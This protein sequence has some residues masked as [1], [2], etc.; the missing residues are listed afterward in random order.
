[1]NTNSWAA[2]VHHISLNS[3]RQVSF[4]LKFG[5]DVGGLGASQLLRMLGGSDS[6]LAALD[7]A[8]Q[9]GDSDEGE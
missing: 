1:M 8:S 4:T 2:V 5:S 3:G 6:Q 7:A 9:L